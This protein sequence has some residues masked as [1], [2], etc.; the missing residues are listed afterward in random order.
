M[1]MIR[2]KSAASPFDSRHLARLATASL[3]TL[4]AMGLLE[5]MEIDRLDL[6]TLRRVV[7]R[8]ADAA[9]I[10]IETQAAL[11]VGTDPEPA[12]I[13]QLLERYQSAIEESPVP[14]YEWR[15]LERLFGREELANLLNISPAS[16]RRY[17]EGTRPTPDAIAA[18]LHFL[19]T[20]VGD[21]AG[22]YND[23]GVRRW[24]QRP[25]Q[26]LGGR[27][28]AAVLGEDWNPDSS[29]AADVRALARSLGSSAVT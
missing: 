17:S 8:T 15:A 10:G 9:G 4:S 3:A 20:V 28:P 21:L 2:I 26:L 1:T 13:E 18:R 14:P 22:A 29:E 24:F 7:D 27:S 23:F 11:S 12:E 19:A 5:D 6:P 25:R 16:V